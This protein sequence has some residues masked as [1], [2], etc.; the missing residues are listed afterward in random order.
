MSTQILASVRAYELEKA[1][2]KMAMRIGLS[3]RKYA[4]ASADYINGR[5]DPATGRA[6]IDRWDRACERRHNALARLTAALR[7]LTVR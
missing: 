3:E 6:L 1:I 4:T 7:D 2:I 5:G